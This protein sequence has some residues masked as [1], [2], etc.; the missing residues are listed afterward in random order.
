[1]KHGLFIQEPDLS[2]L[3]QIQNVKPYFEYYESN[4]FWESVILLQDSVSKEDLLNSLY[5]EFVNRVNEVGVDV[6]EA[7]THAH[8][9]SLVQFICGLGP[10]KGSN[11]L[12]VCWINHLKFY[13]NVFCYVSMMR[14]AEGE[15]YTVCVLSRF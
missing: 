8:T 10:R 2:M 9:S 14:H 7:I 11:L 15:R 6:N 1:M 3:G 12:K 13:M 5:L 4:C